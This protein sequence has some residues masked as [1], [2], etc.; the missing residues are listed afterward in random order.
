MTFDVACL[1]LFLG[2]ESTICFWHSHLTPSVTAPTLHVHSKRE[3]DNKNRR[4]LGRQGNGNAV[5]KRTHEDEERKKNALVSPSALQSQRSGNYFWRRARHS[6]SSKAIGQ[7]MERDDRHARIRFQRSRPTIFR[8]AC[9]LC[10]EPAIRLSRAATRS[11]D[12]KYDP[13]NVKIFLQATD[14]W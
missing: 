7:E 1:K 5:A 8:S 9:K 2:P 6:R 13:S 3:P 11:F 14:E 12:R 4:N 10:Y